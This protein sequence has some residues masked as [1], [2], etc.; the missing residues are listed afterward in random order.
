MLKALKV[1]VPA[2]ALMISTVAFAAT[3]PAA[4]AASDIKVGVVDMQQI[5]QQSPQANALNKQ[6]Q[7]QFQPRQQKLIAAQKNLQSEMDKFN[8]E[9]PT[10]N[11][12]DRTKLQNQIMSDRT[13]FQGMVQSYQQDLSAAQTTAMQKF[14]SDVQDAVG[15]VAKQGNYT[16]IMQRAAAPYADPSLDVTK[17]VLAAMPK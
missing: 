12:A 16:I 9:G 4:A 15:T 3:I 10:M 11:N 7:N 5:L 14:T 6:L 1:V 13:S 2:V 8:K 17:Q